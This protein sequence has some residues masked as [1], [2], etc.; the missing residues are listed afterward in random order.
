MCVCVCVTVLDCSGH[1]D[2]Q[3]IAEL[4]ME[5]SLLGSHDSLVQSTPCPH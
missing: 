5:A 4:L 2:I 1:G 3:R